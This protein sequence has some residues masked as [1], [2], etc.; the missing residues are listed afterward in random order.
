MHKK[1]ARNYG[2][3][4]L[5]LLKADIDGGDKAWKKHALALMTIYG[6]RL[7]G[8]EAHLKALESDKKPAT[9]TPY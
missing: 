8:L 3:A 2:L 5:G 4:T 7:A 9:K 6:E 1:S